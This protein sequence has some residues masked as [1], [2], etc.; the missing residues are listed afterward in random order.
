[1]MEG[2]VKKL[3]FFLIGGLLFL[4]V[5]SLLAGAQSVLFAQGPAK[6][7]S[8]GG[9]TYSVGAQVCQAGVVHTCGS[10]GSWNWST[11]PATKC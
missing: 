7:C 6:P 3:S 10:D 8:Y 4:G 9:N 2:P 11:N 5:G 1:M